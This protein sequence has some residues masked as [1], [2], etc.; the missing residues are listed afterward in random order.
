VT[1]SGRQSPVVAM[2]LASCLGTRISGQSL[3][4]AKTAIPT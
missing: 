4:Q 1:N 2:R 3:F